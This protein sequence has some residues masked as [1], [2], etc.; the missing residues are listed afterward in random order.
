MEEKLKEF[1]HP[2]ITELISQI[3]NLK[4]DQQ[5]LYKSNVFQYFNMMKI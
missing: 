4:S 5:D 1:N 3:E 2:K